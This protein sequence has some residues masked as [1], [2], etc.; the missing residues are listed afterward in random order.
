MSEDPFD[1]SHY[2]EV[3]EDGIA[4]LDRNNQRTRLKEPP[5][6]SEWT[7]SQRL[8]LYGAVEETTKLME[9]RVIRPSDPRVRNQL[10]RRENQR[11]AVT[12]SA[13]VSDIFRDK[14]ASS[15]DKSTQSAP[16]EHAH[17]DTNT[18]IVDARFVLPQYS[19][20]FERFVQMENSSNLLLPYLCLSKN[21]HTEVCKSNEHTNIHRFFQT[22]AKIQANVAKLLE[23][24]AQLFGLRLFSVVIRKDATLEIVFNLDLDNRYFAVVSCGQLANFES[25]DQIVD[26]LEKETKR[27]EQQSEE[28][29]DLGTASHNREIEQLVAAKANGLSLDGPIGFIVPD[30]MVLEQRLML[31]STMLVVYDASLSP[32]LRQQVV[33]PRYLYF[34]ACQ[35]LMKDEGVEAYEN[36]YKEP[37]AEQLLK[38]ARK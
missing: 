33:V 30:P 12:I 13:G 19:R 37:T 5:P 16:F 18:L 10:Q 25:I 35:C 6:L 31:L 27:R 21:M 4:E 34:V 3:E 29:P 11:S 28:R 26:Q 22:H 8:A 1:T 7:T 14:S 20:R 36:A 32:L 2:E 15:F 24:A 38:R 17:I 23:D 9:K